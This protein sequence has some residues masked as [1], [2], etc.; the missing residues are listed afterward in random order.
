[1]ERAGFWK[2]A[3][4]DF[5]AGTLNWKCSP[6]NS[7]PNAAALSRIFLA[8]ALFAIGLLLANL[9]FGLT[10][11]D[12]GAASRQFQAAFHAHETI[13]SSATSHDEL[14]RNA[15]PCGGC[16]VTRPA[17]DA[18]LAAHLAGHHRFVGHV[19]C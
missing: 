7:Y 2:G 10:V 19:A 1:L 16:E 4:G 5:R 9:I 14:E 13:A 3:A 12:F 6:H 17:K 15:S 8:L 18:L 11:G